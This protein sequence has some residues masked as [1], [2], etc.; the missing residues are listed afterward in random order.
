MQKHT[1]MNDFIN[2][3]DN[4]TI[5]EFANKNIFMNRNHLFNFII[6]TY[7]YIYS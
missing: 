3:V 5:K 1:L 2:K 4:N 6:Y 7:I